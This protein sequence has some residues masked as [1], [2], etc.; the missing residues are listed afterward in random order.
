M[1]CKIFYERRIW[2]FL[3]AFF[4]LLMASCSQPGESQENGNEGISGEVASIIYQ[5]CKY[6]NGSFCGEEC[7]A[8]GEACSNREYSYRICDL[9]TGEWKDI[10][11]Y[12]SL[13]SQRCDEV[14]IEEIPEEKAANCTQGWICQDYYHKV[15]QSTGCINSSEEYCERGCL[16]GS[17]ITICSPGEVICSNSILRACSENGNQWIFRKNCG[18]SCDGNKCAEAQAGNSTPPEQPDEQGNDYI[19]DICISVKNF[20]YDAAGSDNSANLNDEYFTLK[21]SCPYSVGMAGWIAKDIA[22]HIFTFPSF[23]L[24]S[25]AEVSVHTGSG[26]NDAS[27]LHWGRSSHVWNNGGDTLYLTNSEGTSVLTYSY[28]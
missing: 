8:F 6:S 24:G 2:L 10:A 27:N 7:C 20:N 12:D 14:K 25:G 16:N 13:C 9:E 22:N 28:P 21:N 15:F 18:A 11:Y 23:N 5:A 17:C 4:L 26:A 3:S 19:A 1:G